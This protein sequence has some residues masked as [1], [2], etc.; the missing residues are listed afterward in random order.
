MFSPI[1]RIIIYSTPAKYPLLTQTEM[2]QEHTDM[3]H[4]QDDRDSESESLPPIDVVGSTG[5]ISEFVPP[6][7]EI[8]TD[9]TSC[10][11]RRIR[12]YRSMRHVMHA[13]LLWLLILA[14]SLTSAKTGRRDTR[15]EIFLNATRFPNLEQHWM[16]INQSIQ[17]STSHETRQLPGD[18]LANRG[19]KPKHP[20]VM[21]PGFVTSS[22][23]LWEGEQ[24]AMKYFRQRMWGALGPARSFFTDKH[25]WRKHLALDPLTGSDPEG[26][27][28]RAAQG[29]DAADYFLTAYWVWNK[30]VDNLAAI[31]YDGSNMSMESYDWRLAF[32]RLEERDGF[33]TKLKHKV[34]AMHK[35][36]GE[37]VVMASHSMGT[38]V[39]IYFFAWVTT[40]EH[41]GGGG[42]G[43]NWVEEHVH[44]TINIAGPLLGVPKAVTSILS[45]DS[46]DTNVLMGTFG[47]MLEQF[48]GRRLRKDLWSSWGS[49]WAMLPKGGD[50]IWGVGADMCNETSVADGVRCVHSDGDAAA[51]SETRSAF[52]EF[53]KE[54]DGDEVQCPSALNEDLPL[55]REIGRFSEERTKSID[56]TIDF[57]M[58]W[59]AGLGP[60][61]ASTQLHDA[62][63]K[64]PSSPQTW[65][66]P[67]RT[68]LPHAP[69]MKIYCLYGVG[70]DTERAFYYRKNTEM[71]EGQ[72]HCPASPVD[73]PFVMDASVEDADQNIDYGVKMVDG[74]GSVPLLSLGYM[75]VD[76]WKKKHMNPSNSPVVTIEYRN[77]NQFSVDDPLRGGPL[78]GDHVDILGNVDM[79]HDF[80]RIV[81]DFDMENVQPKIVSD[82]ERM[83]ERINEHP[84]GGLKAPPREGPMEGLFR[85]FQWF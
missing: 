79:T 81:T 82:I 64:S 53:T 33:F 74:D 47:S 34:E 28:L 3:T 18:I 85:R 16:R 1:V 38:N 57:L 78:S 31:G 77:E 76:G 24:C 55:E 17:S 4:A 63:P 75:C 26:I 83:V 69:S 39:I 58:N 46:K 84:M 52:I 65:S 5:F 50:A 70:I 49:L 66:D 45:G 42:A 35:T 41:L 56:D 23:E 36:T 15:F 71:D 14:F 61:H 60:A 9:D 29:F 11:D 8:D 80:L 43:K 6:L 7:G 68:P 59:G 10:V 51:T 32:P 22:L 2:K 62:N 72:S 21:I 12:S 13:F 54:E 20:I 44:T 25:C 48:F 73:L 27:R 30:L 67:S 37:K 40:P 19:A